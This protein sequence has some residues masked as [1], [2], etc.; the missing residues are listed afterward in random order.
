MLFITQFY[1]DCPWCQYCPCNDNRNCSPSSFLQS[2][3][4]I[5]VSKISP[6]ITCDTTYYTIS[7]LHQRPMLL[8]SLSHHRVLFT[9]TTCLYV[10]SCNSLSTTHFCDMSC[11]NLDFSRWQRKSLL[12]SYIITNHPS[13]CETLSDQINSQINISIVRSPILHLLLMPPAISNYM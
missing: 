4:C 10:S 7:I 12:H 9:T 8:N 1:I 13:I 3:I 5:I 11:C 2:T 6:H